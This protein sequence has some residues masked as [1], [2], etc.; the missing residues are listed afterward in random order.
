MLWQ[1]IAAHPFDSGDPLSFTRRL[2]R[3][4]GWSLPFAQGAVGEYARFCFLAITSPTPVTPSEEVDEVWHLHLAYTRDYWDRWCRTVLQAPLHHDPTRGGPAEQR[5]FRGQY[6]ATLALYEQVFGP[7]PALFWPAT[8][9]RFRARPR[10]RIV[11]ADRFIIIPRP[12]RW[13]RPTQ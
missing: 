12:G 13:L 5:R 2:A 8:H 9:Q 7:P 3:D 6:A 10:Y 4:R 11:D 1:R